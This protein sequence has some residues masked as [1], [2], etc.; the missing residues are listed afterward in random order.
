MKSLHNFV[1]R[2]NGLGSFHRS[3]KRYV[4]KQDIVRILRKL[5]T[6]EGLCPDGAVY[7]MER[8]R[9]IV[10]DF[11]N[12]EGYT[13]PKKSTRS[14]T[15]FNSPCLSRSKPREYVKHTRAKRMQAVK[16]SAE[17]KVLYTGMVGAQ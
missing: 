13:I 12:K 14:P 17:K 7:N 9:R 10:R 5:N 6:N 4:G 11:S 15:G 16:N 2:K 8:V 1:N 3:H